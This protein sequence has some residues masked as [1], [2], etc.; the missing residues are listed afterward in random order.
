M[1]ECLCS[2]YLRGENCPYGGA[3]CKTV[4]MTRA[5]LQHNSPGPEAIYFSQS[6]DTQVQIIGMNRMPDGRF[7]GM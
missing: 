7:S 2:V 5:G 3:E 1:R 4:I 6:C